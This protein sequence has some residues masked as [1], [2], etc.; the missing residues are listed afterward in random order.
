MTPGLVVCD[1]GAISLPATQDGKRMLSDP[2]LPLSG[3]QSIEKRS[4]VIH[5][6]KGKR[7]ACAPVVATQ[8]PFKVSRP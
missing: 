4:I 6:D 1:A 8:A 2:L 5:G 3:P 7:L